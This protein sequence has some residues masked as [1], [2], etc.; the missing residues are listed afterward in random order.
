MRPFHD[1]PAP[2]PRFWSESDTDRWLGRVRRWSI[3]AAVATTTWFGVGIA[4]D[5]FKTDH[6]PYVRVAQGGM[7]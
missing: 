5:S 3:F 6:T 2:L 4:I 7:R 1:Y